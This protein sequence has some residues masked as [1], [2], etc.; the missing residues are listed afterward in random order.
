MYAHMYEVLE[1]GNLRR[2]Y[3]SR[4]NLISHWR[5]LSPVRF[6]TRGSFPPSKDYSWN[7]WNLISALPN[8][9]KSLT[10]SRSVVYLTLL[11]F[12]RIP[13]FHFIV[14]N[15]WWVVLTWVS[16]SIN[17]GQFLFRPPDRRA[18][19]HT[20]AHTPHQKCHYGTSL[21]VEIVC[22][23][24]QNR[25]N[26]F[27]KLEICIVW[28]KLDLLYPLLRPHSLGQSH[29]PANPSAPNIIMY[30]SP[31]SK[32]TPFPLYST[33]RD[34][35]ACLS[36]IIPRPRTFSVV[37]MRQVILLTSVEEVRI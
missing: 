25:Q 5:S 14:C 21:S 9:A 11:S 1:Q 30:I 29:H 26:K 15:G 33:R 6:C 3:Y 34:S 4:Q 20:A 7:C 31:S 13:S 32:L 19:I 22:R 28:L 2:C 36:P 35:N 8:T 23:R 37:L 16:I 10:S 12:S 27:L 24:E 18:S 17:I